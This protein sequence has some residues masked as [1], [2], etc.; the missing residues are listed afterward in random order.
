MDK[1]KQPF[2]GAE[3]AKMVLEVLKSRKTSAELA[4]KFE[5]DPAQIST[6]MEEAQEH[7]SEYFTDKGS[8]TDKQVS[9]EKLVAKLQQQISQLQTEVEWLKKKIDQVE[10]DQSDS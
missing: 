5:V 3:K 4:E 6:W 8:R 2:S 1:K 9:Q 7:L 10:T